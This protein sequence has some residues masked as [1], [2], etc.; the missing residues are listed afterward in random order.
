MSQ[1]KVDVATRTIWRGLPRGIL[2]VVVGG[3]FFFGATQ[4]ARDSD[5]TIGVVFCVILGAMALMLGLGWLACAF[6]PNCYL[7][8]NADGISYRVPGY[9]LVPI[10]QG[11]IAWNQVKGWNPFVN[12]IN[13]LI[14]DLGIQI[15]THDNGLIAIST[16]AF[17]EPVET[18]A[19]N[20]NRAA[21]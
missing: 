2:G 12:K 9:F 13:F 6:A 20:I 19:A 5:G 4:A 11:E 14:S 15:Q 3:A 21:G 7:R 18:I 8:A 10:R 1:A 16:M 17:R